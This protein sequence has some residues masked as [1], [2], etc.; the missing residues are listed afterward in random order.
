M[1]RTDSGKILVELDPSLKSRLYK[2]LD[3][4]GKTMKGWVTDMALWYMA[5]K[6]SQRSARAGF[7]NSDSPRPDT[8][9]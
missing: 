9:K 7:A 1:P 5:W 4:D 6:E 3:S 2:E 8:A